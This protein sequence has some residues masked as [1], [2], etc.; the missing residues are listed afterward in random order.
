MD[1]YY[2]LSPPKVRK[3]IIKRENSNKQ[4]FDL[5]LK[6]KKNSIMDK[7]YPSSP[8]KRERKI[9]IKRENSNKQIFHLSLIKEKESHGQKLRFIPHQKERKRIIKRENSTKQILHSVPTK[10]KRKMKKK[11]TKQTADKETWTSTPN[12]C[13]WYH[14]L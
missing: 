6:K 7:Y 12:N 3:I 9:I 11:I 13:P 4:I 8:T 2:T 14:A 1:K 5:S 10:R